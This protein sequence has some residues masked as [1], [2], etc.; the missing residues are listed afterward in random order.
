MLLS[1]LQNCGS[2]DTTAAGCGVADTVV[3]EGCQVLSSVDFALIVE[4]AVAGALD[5]S[6][7]HII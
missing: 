7:D 3:A 4:L 6:S 1:D 5:G 2:W